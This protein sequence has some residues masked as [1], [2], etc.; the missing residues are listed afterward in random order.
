MTTQI[1]RHVSTAIATGRIYSPDLLA[2][3]QDLLSELADL[4]CVFEME[5]EA[6]KASATSEPEDVALIQELQQRH[7]E[8]CAP[9]IMELTILEKKI[10]RDCR[11]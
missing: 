11:L 3:M 7:R 1:N 6:A 8:Q 4:R 5:L 2:Q 10:A 9:I